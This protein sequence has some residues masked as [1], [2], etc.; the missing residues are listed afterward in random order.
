MDRITTKE[1]GEVFE[2]HAR[3]EPTKE[4]EDLTNPEDKKLLRRID[5]YLLPLLTMSYFLQFLDKQT[6]NFS[7]VMGL[8]TDLHL[9]KFEYSLSSSMFYIGYLAFSWPASFLMVRLP[10][11]KYLS[12]TCIVWAACLACHAATTN[13]TGLLVVRFF[14][15]AAEASISPGFSL[16]TGMWYKREEQPFRHGIWFFGNSVATMFGSLFAYAIAHISG[17]I[18]P[19]RWLFIIFGIATLLWGGVLLWFLPDEPS[20]ARWLTEEQ[21]KQA[22]DRIRTNQTGTKNSTF[23][24]DQAVEALTDIKVWLL[25]LY[26]LANSIPNGAITT[27]SSL[28][29]SGLGFG[30]LQVY[31]LQMPIGVIHGIFALD[32]T[33]LCS[34]F[35][36]SRC[37]IAA[38]L[39][40]IS[41]IGSILVRFGPNIGSN[42]FG[43]FIFIAYAAGIPIS[44]SMITSNVAGFTK[45]AVV[46][47]MMFVAYC[48]G[49][50][51]GPFLFFSSEAPTYSVSINAF[52][53]LEMKLTDIQSGFLAT[54]ICFA[55][56]VLFI[57]TL[58]VLLARENA[59]RDSMQMDGSN[60]P[61]FDILEIHDR[62]DKTNLN[63]RYVL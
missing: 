18:G 2:I 57:T 19:W 48:A 11:G 45:K 26:Q 47:G 38:A 53:D 63:F 20:K 30:R 37:L 7:S 51:I 52:P 4:V 56:A 41:L 13:A 33:Y 43:L 16:I 44:L 34:R 6:L 23:K 21:R 49:N 40:I 62:T 22:I 39:S 10:I 55:M 60:Q 12:G 29:V 15:G 36:N 61:T 17:G 31:L 24:W 25:V 54:I 28:V 42:L 1:N 58:R 5:L 14:L 9:K 35:K 8:I 50:I 32:S 27:F 46:T 59:R 3:D